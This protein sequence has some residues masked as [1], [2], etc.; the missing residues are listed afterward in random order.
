MSEW[1]VKFSLCLEML[2]GLT[3][4]L[5]HY[6]NTLVY[7]DDLQSISLG[8]FSPLALQSIN[9]NMFLSSNYRFKN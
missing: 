1:T 2:M 6:S 5:G 3:F 9:S 4:P 8:S 7:I